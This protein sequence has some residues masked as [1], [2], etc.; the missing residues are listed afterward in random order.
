MQL[1]ELNETRLR[2]LAALRPEG[3]RVLSVFL[4]LDPAEFA[5]P[6][7]RATEISSVL[8]DADRQARDAGDLPHNALLGLRTDIER[9]RDHLRDYSPKG[10]HGLA[11]Y[12]CGAAGLFEVI[13]LPRPVQTRAVIDDSPLVEPLVELSGLG[14]WL[15]LLVNREVGRMF[16]GD[17]EGFEELPPVEDEVHGRHSQGG[18]SQAR[19][20]RSVDEEVQDHLRRVAEAAFT[21]FKRSPFDGLILGGPKDVVAEFE[22]KLHD[23]LRQ[24]LSGRI[25]V[26]VENTPV[27]DVGAAAAR[28]LDEIDREREHE[29]LERLREGVARGGRGA[30]GLE[31]VLGAL[32]ERRVETLLLASGYSAAGSTCPQCGWVGTLDGGACPADGTRLDPRDDVTESAVELALAQSADVLVV[33]DEEHA[34]ELQSHGAVGALLRF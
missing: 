20:Q 21:R 18:L 32:N 5:S 31:D 33:R 11:L 23:Y 7:A 14:T 10:A 30:A 12:A 15:V 16:R 2:E 34:R 6:P 29:T 3:A 17:R 1:N 19:Y 28:R 22:G 8:D 24:R 25:E 9:A 26:D 4:D 13:R 27:D